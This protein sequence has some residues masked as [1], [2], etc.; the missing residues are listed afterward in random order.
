VNTIVLIAAIVLV[1]QGTYILLQPLPAYYRSFGLLTIILAGLG[2]LGY[3]LSVSGILIYSPELGIVMVEGPVARVG[4]S[5]LGFGF[6]LVAGYGWR[7]ARMSAGWTGAIPWFLAT[8]ALVGALAVY[9]IRPINPDALPPFRVYAYN[10]WWP[11][12][13]IWVSLCVVE[14]VT[15]ILNVRHRLI[16]LLTATAVVATLSLWG[17]HQPYS[18]NA[19]LWAIS[20]MI[21]FPATIGIAVVLAARPF[22]TNKKVRK[23]V[24]V[25]A[26]TVGLVS[27]FPFAETGDAPMFW[28]VGLPFFI[29]SVLFAAGC[30]LFTAN[31]NGQLRFPE[32]DKAR[33]EYTRRAIIVAT[34]L[35]IAFS[36][37][38]FFYNV[39]DLHRAFP[40]ATFFIAWGILADFVTGKGFLHLFKQSIGSPES[41]KEFLIKAWGELRAMVMFVPNGIRDFFK[42]TKTPGAVM[43]LVVGLLLLIALSEIPNAGKTIIVPFKSEA[44]KN[45]EELDQQIADRI[46]GN[47]GLVNHQLRSDIIIPDTHGH[48]I[49]V[50]PSDGLSSTDIA[51]SNPID[52]G[53]VS[54]PVSLFLWP[55]QTPVRSLLDVDVI[56]G[57]LHQSRSGYTLLANSTSGATW[58][59]HA[60]RDSGERKQQVDPE[61]DSSNDD[62]HKGGSGPDEAAVNEGDPIPADA[63]NAL[64]VE[65]SFKI[66]AANPGIQ[67]LGMTQSW[68][69]FQH[70]QL[71]LADYRD[72][73]QLEI[74]F[75][76]KRYDKITS[77]IS[78]LRDAV[79]E[80]PNFALAHYRLGL[81]LQADQQFG[82]ATAAFRTSR[83]VNPDFM[84]AINALAYSLY[85]AVDATGSP[86]SDD[87]A[88]ETSNRKEARWLW[89]Q[90]LSFDAASPEELAMAYGG[91]GRMHFDKV[92]NNVA[93][94]ADTH[95]L[96]ALYYLERAAKI[97]ERMSQES[98]GSRGI[99][100]AEGG[101]LNDLGVLHMFAARVTGSRRG[102]SWHCYNPLATVKEVTPSDYASS[103]LSRE[104]YRFAD[105]AFGYFVRAL[106]LQP[107]D[108]VMRCNAADAADLLGNP[109]PMAKL[110]HDTNVRVW[111]AGN[112]KRPRSE[113]Y[114]EVLDEYEAAISLDRSNMLAMNGFAYS[115]WEWRRDIGYVLNRDTSL[116]ELA[117]RA[118]GHIRYALEMSSGR[119]DPFEVYYL[120]TLAG[121][122]LAQSRPHEAIEVITSNYD[123]LV[124]RHPLFNE[125]RWDLAQAY[126]CAAYK[127]RVWLENND[128]DEVRNP[129][130]VED[131]MQKAEEWIR[132]IRKSEENRESQP[133]T[134]DTS[135]LDTFL[136]MVAACAGGPEHSIYLIEDESDAVYVMAPEVTYNEYEVCDWVGVA[137]V[138]VDRPE[139][140]NEAELVLH[141]WG[142][143]IHRM[144]AR[145]TRSY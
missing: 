119:E 124:P 69:A 1:A 122:L 34:L 104:A 126:L 64:A 76:P 50:A 103:E 24:A 94:A 25:A 97:Y 16:R 142:G 72:F 123:R 89:Q 47:L 58:D 81:A 116:L 114:R 144:A 9:Q 86:A 145:R 32:D 39:T 135:R 131:Y 120:E 66:L 60:P 140:D 125:I 101:L 51:K 136:G 68:D 137:G 44:A 38:A 79:R 36:I 18:V 19:P 37:A 129:A 14:S 134:A 22:V 10:V 46:I 62:V 78:Y 13:S 6:A 52:V 109:G 35:V 98:R 91:L 41:F 130:H 11:I 8:G 42:D 59:A 7:I 115:F 138:I 88:I 3:Q 107:D 90:V 127:D 82:T 12:F 20:M 45:K 71:G 48:G 21:A 102:D 132:K 93:D 106:A 31:K 70:Y 80:D 26:A 139:N 73:E 85:F 105:A 63:L 92:Y 84:P 141:M 99:R 121:V 83:K 108:P 55:I 17:L 33:D 29:L 53:G 40:L 111:R 65:L 57:S 2:F 96:L 77:A 74:H 56:G 30:A 112:F 143:D 75:T 49:S 67:R 15:S 28:S 128:A 4:L 117:H 110:E 54:I 133:Y 118:E 87:F 100:Q 23:F 27:V 43:H 5:V 95:G 61:N 113:N